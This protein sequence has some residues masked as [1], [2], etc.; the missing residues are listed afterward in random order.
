MVCKCMKTYM[1]VYVHTLKKTVTYV[2]LTNIRMFSDIDECSEGT[3]NCFQICTNTDGS[4]I[5]GCNSGY[6]LDSD[7]VT[8]IG[9]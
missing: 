1:Y 6:A 3:H 4:F 5:C 9:M 7:G 8:C 2:I